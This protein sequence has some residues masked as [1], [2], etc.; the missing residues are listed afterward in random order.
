M[1]EFSFHGMA[2]VETLFGS[3]ENIPEDV[4]DEMLRQGAAVLEAEQRKQARAFRVQD[5]G[6]MI[7]K[8]KVGRIKRLKDGSKAI[9]ITPTGTRTRG[10]TKTRNAEIAF[11]AEYGKKTQKARPFLA[12]A[13]AK[14]E[15]AIIA[16]EDKVYGEYLEKL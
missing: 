3:L 14:A 1:A 13:M 15:D 12:T 11:I 2:E 8:I 4:Q 9:Y 5:T 16:A 7:R 10:K 6:L